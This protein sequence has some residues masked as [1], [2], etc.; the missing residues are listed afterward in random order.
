MPCFIHAI[1]SNIP[2]LDLLHSVDKVYMAG[3]SNNI[4]TLNYYLHTHN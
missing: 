4:Y 1:T 3:A 2:Y